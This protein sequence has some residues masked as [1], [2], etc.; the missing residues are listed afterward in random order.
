MTGI[1]DQAH[2]H[3]NIA[4]QLS[5]DRRFRPEWGDL[6]TLLQ[7]IDQT[8]CHKIIVSSED[9]EC[10]LLRPQRINK[11]LNEFKSKNYKVCILIY[12]RNPLDYLTSLYLELLK[13][14]LGDEFNAYLRKVILTTKFKYKEWEFVFNHSEMVKSINSIKDIE[15]MTR[16]YDH[17]IENDT[18][19]DFC[20][21]LL[22]DGQKINIPQNTN[23]LNRRHETSTLLKLF[24]K[25]RTNIQLKE[26]LE[27]VDELLEFRNQNL[28]TS[29]KVKDLFNERARNNAFYKSKNTNTDSS[30]K[31]DSLNIEKFF[32]FETC[33]L[34]TA[35]N[36]WRGDA[37]R[38][39]QL[40][41]D[42]RH[43]VKQFH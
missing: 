35:L 23:R 37:G 29:Q 16:D 4:W 28:E 7:E 14:G 39:S 41:A 33:N 31:Y 25:N 26:Q 12:L 11:L 19:L 22:L 36:Q 27:V 38:K 2:G 32:S 42:W 20:N 21:A 40:I 43:W 3:H 1:P 34:L 18:V 6:R 13:A 9:F 17:L 10:S 5:H 15:L 24:F 30:K 8:D